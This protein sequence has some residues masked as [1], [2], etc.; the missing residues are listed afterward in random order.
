MTNGIYVHSKSFLREYRQGIMQ[1]NMGGTLVNVSAIL[2]G[3][4]LGWRLQGRL[5]SRFNQ[6]LIQVLGVFTL[7]LGVQMFVA[8]ADAGLLILGAVLGGALLGEGLQLDDAL[9]QLGLVLEK[10][11]AGI[12]G[13]DR[14][15]SKAF[16][17][18]SLLF[19]VG[20][21][22]ILGAIQD[23]LGRDPSILYVKAIM[24][25]VI[26]IAFAATLGLGTAFSALPVL[27]YQGTLTLLAAQAQTLMTPDVIALING[28]GGL[29]LACIGL[30]LLEIAQIKVTNLLPGFGIVLL[31][32]VF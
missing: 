28:V 12:S 21:M 9:Q 4:A 13:V 2:L 7:L 24:D 11:L 1:I 22:A 27:L 30:N 14:R 25:G 19:A 20:P 18:S 23:G 16:V 8:G 5:P 31:L 15:F 17:T 6:M 10:R 29:M 26:S 3:C 32:A